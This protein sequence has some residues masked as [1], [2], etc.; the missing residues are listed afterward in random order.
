V[1]RLTTVLLKCVK[2]RAVVE[3][4]EG[5]DWGKAPEAKN[6]SMGKED[7]GFR[8]R[9]EMPGLLKAEV[10]RGKRRGDKETR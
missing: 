10:E 4:N 5:K 2:T 3:P 6:Y 9:R 8:Y 1:T 7:D